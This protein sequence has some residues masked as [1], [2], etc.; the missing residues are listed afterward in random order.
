MYFQ[1]KQPLFFL[2]AKTN[3]PPRCP[4]KP[5][6]TSITAVQ[7]LLMTFP[8]LPNHHLRLCISHIFNAL[9]CM[10]MKLHPNTFIRYINKTEGIAAKTMHT[11]VCCRNPPFTH[12]Y[13]YLMQYFQQ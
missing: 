9:L 13:G 8:A 11:P 3:C 2:L 12:G 4:A 7:I 5:I 10:E 1:T 6:T